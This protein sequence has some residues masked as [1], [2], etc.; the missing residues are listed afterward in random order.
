[1]TKELIDKWRTEADN[2]IQAGGVHFDAKAEA[3]H[4]CADEL[5]AE[6]SIFRDT[7]LTESRDIKYALDWRKNVLL[8]F[9]DSSIPAVVIDCIKNSVRVMHAKRFFWIRIDNANI[10]RI[11]LHELNLRS[12]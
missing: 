4:E 1:V 9:K 5:E 11:V 3:I 7:I 2:L 12:V 6:L 8:Y 10:E